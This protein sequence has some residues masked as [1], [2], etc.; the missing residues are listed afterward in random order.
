MGR[1]V[2][3]LTRRSLPGIYKVLKR[4][5]FSRKQAQAF[6]RSPDTAYA[7]K[8]RAIL[9]AY[10]DAVE[11]PEQ[12][13]LLFR[14]ELTYWRR[15]AVRAVHQRRGQKQRRVVDRP[16]ANTQ[17][18]LIA[19]VNACTGQVTYRQRS[20]VGRFELVAFYEQVRQD[21]PAVLRLYLV[22]DNW[23]THKH[24][25]VLEAAQH[26]ALRLLFL[27]T[28]ASWRSSGAGCGRMCSIAIPSPTT[29]TN[30]AKRSP[31][32]STA[33]VPARATCCSSSACFRAPYLTNM[34]INLLMSYNPAFLR[35]TAFARLTPRRVQTCCCYKKPG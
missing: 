7:L 13:V 24:P 25:L 34:E 23:P 27:P 22:L 3:W 10:Q 31:V 29:S 26:H 9:A 35:P 19:V 5:G 21:Y 16:G 30:S 20:H 28:Y 33:S 8:W 2:S 32:G 11:H 1:V 18:R 14:D 4:L 12:A 6:I 17:T 15:P